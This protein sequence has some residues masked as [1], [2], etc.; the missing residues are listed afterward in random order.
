MCGRDLC[1]FSVLLVTTEIM[2]WGC[3]LLWVLCFFFPLL[4][5]LKLITISGGKTGT[6]TG[7]WIFV[8]QMM[9]SA[10]HFFQV[11]I[12]T[13]LCDINCF[14]IRCLGCCDVPSWCE[15]E[16]RMW[17]A[18]CSYL[19]RMW[20]VSVFSCI[21]DFCYLTV[22]QLIC[23]SQRLENQNSSLKTC[24]KSWEDE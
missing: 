20:L 8:W 19:L 24:F 15:S 4:R 7:I 12:N 11:V 22:A 13:C 16:R 5:S 23:Q 10:E 6:S 9:P 18:G 14:W 17:S 1:I 2:V 3:P 21:N